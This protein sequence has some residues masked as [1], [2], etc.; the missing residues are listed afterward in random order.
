MPG[1]KSTGADGSLSNLRRERPALLFDA[2]GHSRALFGATDG[3]RKA[4]RTSFNVHLPLRVA[5]AL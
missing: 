5:P 3:H 2:S 4:G 1:A